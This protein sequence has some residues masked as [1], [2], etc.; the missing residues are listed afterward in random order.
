M[1]VRFSSCRFAAALAAAPKNHKRSLI[2]GTHDPAFL[3]DKL[4]AAGPLWVN[5][6]RGVI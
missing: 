4:R 5:N 6:C 1:R 3:Q 2:A